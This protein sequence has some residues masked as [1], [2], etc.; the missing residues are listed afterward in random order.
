M[1]HNAVTSE[2]VQRLLD[3]SFQSSNRLARTSRE[4]NILAHQTRCLPDTHFYRDTPIHDTCMPGGVIARNSP[5]C[6]EYNSAQ[7][8]RFV[9]VLI[10]RSL[11]MRYDNNFTRQRARLLERWVRARL[12][13][14]RGMLPELLLDNER[15]DILVQWLQLSRRFVQ[16]P[17]L[18]PRFM[19]AEK[20]ANLDHFVQHF[21]R[22]R[23]SVWFHFRRDI[24][25][26]E[27]KTSVVKSALQSNRDNTWITLCCNN[28]PVFVGTIMDAILSN[29]D[30]F[31]MNST[32][33][34]FVPSNHINYMTLSQLFLELAA[35]ARQA[36]VMPDMEQYTRVSIVLTPGCIAR[37]TEWLRAH[38][39]GIRVGEY[40]FICE[41]GTQFNLRDQDMDIEVSFFGPDIRISITLGLAG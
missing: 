5:P 17:V 15:Y 30:A 38:R 35:F 4:N 41:G 19:N 21:C 37:N 18:M 13:T 16:L 40:I 10:S 39:R 3:M 31:S 25:E 9:S 26:S 8:M 27:A 6:C 33:F 20:N 36:P 32:V 14:T 1:A 7:I 24:R 34:T 11:D 29:I 23:D 2:H 22:Q 12:L 28:E